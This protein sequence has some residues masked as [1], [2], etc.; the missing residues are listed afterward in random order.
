MSQL[1]E[2]REVWDVKWT[3][4]WMAKERKTS[5]EGTKRAQAFPD[6]EEIAPV[7]LNFGYWGTNKAS[8]SE[9]VYVEG[10]QVKVKARVVREG[11]EV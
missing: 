5:G 1:P 8:G 9:Y 3:G 6:Y 4:R 10:M 7:K 11:W 2:C